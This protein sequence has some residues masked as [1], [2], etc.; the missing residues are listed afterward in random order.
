VRSFKLRRGSSEK[1]QIKTRRREP[2]G[3]MHISVFQPT[4]RFYNAELLQRAV[5]RRK[6]VAQV[7]AEAVNGGD[8]CEGDACGNEAIFNGRSSGFVLQEAGEK[9]GHPKLLVSEGVKM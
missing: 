1:V 7:A 4:L 6:L 8:D 5:D 9:F 3:L 2:A